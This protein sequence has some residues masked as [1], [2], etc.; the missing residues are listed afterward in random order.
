M[1]KEKMTEKKATEI[2]I[3]EAEYDL[4]KYTNYDF[5]KK[6]GRQQH[7]QQQQPQ[8]QQPQPQ[9][10]VDGKYKAGQD[11]RFGVTCNDPR[12]RS[13]MTHKDK[14]GGMQKTC[15]FG[16]GCGDKESACKNWHPRWP[17]ADETNT[18]NNSKGKGGGKGGN[19]KVKTD[20]EKA[21]MAPAYSRE[22][23]VSVSSR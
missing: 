22:K 6:A 16:H 23:K 19:R 13:I 4:E 8:Q 12:C 11:C 10:R 15:R 1:D 9:G 21:K 2:I 3:V 5:E 18:T 7:V 20:M 17:R 14:D